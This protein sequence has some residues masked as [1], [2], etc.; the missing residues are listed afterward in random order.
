MGDY[1]FLGFFPKT[2]DW[3]SVE[4]SASFLSWRNV[5]PLQ[6]PPFCF[7]APSSRYQQ[8]RQCCILTRIKLQ[9]SLSQQ[10]EKQLT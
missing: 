9:I 5:R 6:P 4:S 2:T 3:V 7:G 1:F 8:A 10:V